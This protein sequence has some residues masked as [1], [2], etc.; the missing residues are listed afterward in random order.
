LRSLFSKKDFLIKPLERAETIPSRWYT[1]LA[2]FE[3]DLNSVFPDTW[4]YAG[5]VS[6]ARNPGD[7]FLT[8]VARNPVIVIRGKD[9]ILRAFYNVCRHRGGPLAIEPQGHCNVL[10][11]KYH[12]WT[13]LLDGSLRG[14][15]KF[16]RSELFDRKD[17]GLVPVQLEVWE[18]LIFVNLSAKKPAPVSKIMKGITERIA[19]ESIAKKKFHQRVIYEVNANWKVYCD[20][21]LEGYHLPIVHPGLTG[22]LD[23]QNYVTEVYENYST[24]YSGIRGQQNFYASPEGMAIY[25]FVFPN[26]MLNI[27]P[28]RLQVNHVLPVAPDRCSVIFDYFYDDTVSPA[29][30]QKI[31]DDLATSEAI[32]QE[33]AMICEKVQTGLGS[34]AYHTGRYSPEMEEGVYDFHCRLKKIYKSFSEKNRDEMMRLVQMVIFP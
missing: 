2:V 33:D 6:M 13:Y 34:R 16:D 12:G 1:D 14:T 22:M 29:A 26:F 32:Q 8:T 7:Y 9:N 11:C 5:P 10:Q 19:P 30:L 25:Y 27:L 3:V 15:P 21:Y 20:N 24:Q 31:Q 18:N 17:Y 4:Q 23:Y 28:G